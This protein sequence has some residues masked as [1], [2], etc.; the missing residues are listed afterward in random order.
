M[1]TSGRK[2]GLFDELHEFQH[3]GRRVL[4]RFDDDGVAGSQGRRELPRGEKQGRIPRNDRCDNAERFVSRVIE[5]VGLVDGN[6]GAL[7]LVGQAAVVAVPLRHVCRLAAHFSE[8]LAVVAYFELRQVLRA[9][10]N[11]I[12]KPPKQ[13]ATAGRGQPRPRAGRERFVRGTHRAVDVVGGAQW[14]QRPRL[15]EVGIVA[16]ETVVR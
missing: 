1:P 3:G 5:R 8:Q 16:F 9:L 14:N 13:C 7:D 2:A 11:Q 12:A 15:S 10:R 4:G 6:D